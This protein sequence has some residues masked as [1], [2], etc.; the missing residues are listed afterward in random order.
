MANA[1]YDTI[2][3]IRLLAEDEGATPGERAAAQAKLEQYK[4]AIVVRPTK[5][6]VCDRMRAKTTTIVADEE[7]KLSCIRH[8]VEKAEFEMAEYRIAQKTRV[9]KATTDHELYMIE[10]EGKLREAQHRAEI[11]R[12]KLNAERASLGLGPL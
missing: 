3:K 1:T 12:V 2:Y 10:A 6:T 4:T 11:A 7:R 9:A 5:M 8:A